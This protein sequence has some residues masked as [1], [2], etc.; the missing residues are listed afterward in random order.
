VAFSPELNAV[1][2]K[3][4]VWLLL[5][6]KA[7]GRK[8]S[9]W[10][11]SRS[12]RKANMNQEV[13]L[14]S[15]ETLQE[16]LKLAYQAYYK[17]KGTANELRQTALENLAAAIALTGNSTQEKTLKQLRERESQRQT[18]RRLRYL[19]GKLR[20]G[21]TT[22]VT[23]VDEAGNRVDITN[24]H[25]TEKAILDNNHKKNLQSSHTPIYLSPLREEFGFKGLTS[26]AQA[27]LA[28]IYES[29]HD[30]DGRILDVITQWQMP[31]AV[32]K[33]GPLQMTLRVEIYTAFWRKAQ[34]N[35]ACYPSELSFSTMK[36]GASDPLIAT[37]DCQRTRIPLTVSFA[38]KR[39]GHCLDIMILKKS[40]V[41]DLTGL[42]TIILFPV[43]CNYAF[44][45]VGIEM[46]KVAEATKALAP[47]QYG[48]R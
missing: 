34:E 20:S 22:I 19:R 15:E 2:L 21:S 9:S 31:K 39:W 33:L 47:N 45:H 4:K 13:K 8:V 46:M 32:R 7:K 35:T 42:R 41:T 30:I 1:R 24:Q 43:D 16:Q 37:P 40:G 10:L 11:I 6:S 36:A 23:T 14:F 3:I 48:S 5:V 12:I 17:V 28:G 18:A 38:P 44:K 27:A 26:S 25:D 29:N